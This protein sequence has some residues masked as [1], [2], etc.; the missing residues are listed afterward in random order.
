MINYSEKAGENFKKGYNCSQS[1]FLTFAKELGLEDEMALKLDAYF[2]ATNYLS[3]GQLYLLDNHHHR[4]AYSF[5]GLSI[6]KS[7]ND[8][9]KLYITVIIDIIIQSKLFISAL[10]FPKFIVFNFDYLREDSRLPSR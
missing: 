9:C 6:A 5:H 4:N 2:R 1:V 7:N 3:V 10:P 8:G